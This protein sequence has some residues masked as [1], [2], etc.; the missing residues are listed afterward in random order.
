M[1]NNEMH[2]YLTCLRKYA[3]FSGKSSRTEYWKFVSV[4]FLLSLTFAAI[5]IGIDTVLDTASVARFVI[6]DI[7]PTAVWLFFAYFIF[8]LIPYIATTVRRLH[9]VGKSG[10]WAAPFMISFFTHVNLKYF[11]DIGPQATK[12][13]G[14]AL[15]AVAILV[16]FFLIQKGNTSDI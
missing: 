1:Y 11:F 12:I 3:D 5:G 10:W 13:L 2:S 8:R 16:I 9:D 6:I 7:G 14:V 15:S 4:D